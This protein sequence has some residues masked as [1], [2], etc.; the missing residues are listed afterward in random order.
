MVWK[1]VMIVAMLHAALETVSMVPYRPMPTVV[2][3][4]I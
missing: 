3:R 1:L 4:R 2:G